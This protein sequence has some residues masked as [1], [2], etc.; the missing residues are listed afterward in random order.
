V[1]TQESCW[2]AFWIPAFAGMSELVAIPAPM[3]GVHGLCSMRSLESKIM[4]GLVKPGHDGGVED[5]PWMAEGRDCALSTHG[6]G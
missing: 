6:G 1:R 2:W 5:G 3:A 4:D